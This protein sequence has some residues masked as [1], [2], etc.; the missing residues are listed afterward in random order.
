MVLVK[1]VMTNNQGLVTALCES[2]RTPG[3]PLSLSELR[4]LACNLPLRI[5]LGRRNLSVIQNLITGDDGTVANWSD[6]QISE[7][8]LQLLTC[9]SGIQSITTLL[10]NMNRLMS[11]PLSIANFQQVGEKTAPG[12]IENLA[13]ITDLKQKNVKLYLNITS[14]ERW[15]YTRNSEPNIL[16]TCKVWSCM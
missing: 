1:G 6:L 2:C 10:L 15:I 8:D 7:P 14:K 4:K 3:A 16:S 9:I 5:S 11:L 13:H 12:F